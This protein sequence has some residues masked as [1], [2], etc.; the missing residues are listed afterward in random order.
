MSDKYLIK[1]KD[2]EWNLI[3]TI[4]P[5]KLK[6]KIYFSENINGPQG[7]LT[8]VLD[9]DS[10]LNS[11]FI[12]QLYIITDENPLWR[13][14]YTWF[15]N[16]QKNLKDNID[17]LTLSFVWLWS[18]LFNTIYFNYTDNKKDYQAS[19]NLNISQYVESIIDNLSTE[20]FNWNLT[21]TFNI[22]ETVTGLTSWAI[23]V[24]QWF[25]SESW[26]II[27]VKVTS[28]KFV[29]AETIKGDDSGA[30]LWSIFYEDYWAT[31]Y[32]NLLTSWNLT[33]STST[34]NNKWDYTSNWELLNKLKD[35][36][37]NLYYYIDEKW[38]I[39]FK[40]KEIIA[41]LTNTIVWDKEILSVEKNREFDITNKIHLKIWTW[42]II[43]KK[44]SQSILDYWLFEKMESDN[45]I[46]DIYTWELKAESIIT[47][48]KNPTW[49]I[50]IKVN[51]QYDRYIWWL[52]WWQM[53]DTWWNY[54]VTWW[55]LSDYKSIFDFS[56]W[57]MIN[58]RNIDYN[59][60]LSNL[61]I[62]RKE[63]YQDYTILYCD[64]YKNYTKNILTNNN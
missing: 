52:T 55:E 12:C 21:W 6:N 19:T 1:L 22:W 10:A 28:W 41:P 62:V 46:Q 23:W 27:F 3:G 26:N 4:A 5:S 47:K 14:L 42:D 54:N 45:T 7:E 25:S 43:V 48:N 30:E 18:L 13:L 17:E 16:K 24:I 63:F 34:F 15:L 29:E 60:D 38:I 39:N 44:D 61:L 35:S 50:K 56:V 32:W 9:S 59:K 11:S 57:D 51:N 20:E 53:T 64:K 49:E 40:E 33:T 58:I 2:I 36:D 37:S 31:V 8:L